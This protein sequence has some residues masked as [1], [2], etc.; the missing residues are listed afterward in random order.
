VIPR[1]GTTPAGAAAGAAASQQAPA[2]Q[3]L[4]GALP[5][6]GLELAWFLLAALLLIGAG[7][8]TRRSAWTTA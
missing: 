3:R 1:A 5:F 4:A 6:T 8:A 7:V 2:A